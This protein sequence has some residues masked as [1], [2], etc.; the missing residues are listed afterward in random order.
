MTGADIKPGVYVTLKVEDNGSGMDEETMS[1]M[2]DPFFTTKFVGRGLGL[3]AVYGIARGHEAA[4]QVSSTSKGSVFTVFLSL[5]E[6]DG[7]PAADSGRQELQGAG[8]ILV[9]DDEEMVREATRKM[10]EYFGYNA[11]LAQDGNE[12]VEI[13]RSSAASISLVLLDLT[14]PGLSGDQVLGLLKSIRPD[15][16]VVIS[17]GYDESEVLKL[18]SGC[19]VGFI[20]KPYSAWQLAEKV[21]AVLEVRTRG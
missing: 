3:A 8:T 5:S 12:A 1:M 20:Q 18:F 17:S 2:F 21:K 15:A 6:K 16:P 14:M 11:L 9:V 19:D 10:L 13:F 7:V 4:I